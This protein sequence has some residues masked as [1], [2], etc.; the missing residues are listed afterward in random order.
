MLNLRFAFRQLRQSP[1]F[2]AV[3]IL[4]LALGIGANTAIFSL[5][6]GMLLKKLPVPEPEQLVLFNWAASEGVGPRSHS[7][8][9]ETI[10]STGERTSTSFSHATFEHFRAPSQTLRDVFAFAPLWQINASWQGQ[11]ENLRS[12]VTV[13]GNYHQALGVRFPLGRGLRPSDDTADAPPVAVISDRYW[14]NRFGGSPQVLNETLTLNGV[15]FTIVGVTAPGFHGTGQVGEVNDVYVPFA[16]YRLL[17]PGDTEAT[18]PW[19]WA[20]RI[21]GRMADGVTLEQVNAEMAGRFAASYDGHLRL[22]EGEHIRLR[23]AS[24]TTGLN[25]DRR[26]YTSSLR[27]LAA[28]VGLVLLVACANVANLLLA[29][30]AARER[31]LAVRIALGASRPRLIA[32]LLTESLL[33][34]VCGAALGLLISLWARDAFL[35]LQPFGGSSF[36]LDLGLDWRVLGFT[37][38]IAVLT[39]VLF[40]TLPALRATRRDVVQGFQGGHK[41]LGAPR[42]RLAQTL[43]VLQIALSLVLL[44]GAGLFSR[45]LANLARSDIGFERDQ[46]LLFA[47]DAMPAGYDRPELDSVYD[48]VRDRLKA[49]PGV[50]AVAY[51]RVPL[52]SGSR[53]TSSRAIEGHADL[54]EE[55]RTIVMNGVS[56][57]FLDT[58]QWPLLLGRNFTLADSTDAP[59]VIIVNQAFADRYYPGESA[60]GH[61]VGPSDDNL[62]T[63]IIGVVA[64]GKTTDLREA[65][66]PA[67]FVPHAQLPNARTGHF[68][69]RYQGGLAPL[70]R[71]LT[72]AVQEIE[73]TLPIIALRTQNEQINRLLR[74]ER[75]FALLTSSFGLLALLLAAVGLYG[76][77]A[78]SVVRRTGEIGLRMA[79]GALPS[80]VRWLI[81]RDCLRLAVLGVLVGAGAA[82]L[83]TRLISSQLYGLSP[84]DPAVYVASSLVLLAVALAAAL[85]PARRATT[86]S[87]MVALRSE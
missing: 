9:S 55:N 70:Q 76:L 75:I 15:P 44:I 35:A 48:R 5:V 14:Q 79:L 65:R 24:G 45:T 30:G 50:D 47:L 74:E 52:L 39:G 80:G 3:T 56:P 41:T 84:L 37:A 1:G 16:T 43:M 22:D 17:E 2:A 60:I 25:E 67:A 31:E 8:Y 6:N 42:S 73:P 36:S 61:R 81:L 26:Q 59:R 63:E 66:R 34:S 21:M 83:L 78:Y 38:G 40:G 68:A 28:I 86:V 62:N 7:G 10:A 4:S 53:W 11:A 77:L 71:A 82:A 58:V 18:E 46:L 54:P 23:T 27:I 19:A 69:L 13:S 33:L 57:E 20:I 87:P 51:S 49:L 85:I 29:R 64:D 72:A 32:Q 12:A